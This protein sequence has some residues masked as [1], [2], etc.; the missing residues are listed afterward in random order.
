[1]FYCKHMFLNKYI[2]LKTQIYI[3]DSVFLDSQSVKNDPW[4]MLD[5]KINSTD[6]IVQGIFY[7][8]F[9]SSINVRSNI[10]SL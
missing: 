8:T 2:T 10:S 4:L 1:M 7:F 9:D 5:S 3:W 6:I